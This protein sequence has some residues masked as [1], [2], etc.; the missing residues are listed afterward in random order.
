[1]RNWSLKARV[2]YFNDISSACDVK[3]SQTFCN[4]SSCPCFYRITFVTPWRGIPAE[5]ANCQ[6]RSSRYRP[7]YCCHYLI[8]PTH[9][10]SHSFSHVCGAVTNG[11]PLSTWAHRCRAHVPALKVTA[12]PSPGP[13]A[14][15][16][17]FASL[18]VCF[19]HTASIESCSDSHHL[20]QCVLVPIEPS[21]WQ[22]ILFESSTRLVKF[23]LRN[24]SA[25]VRSRRVGNVSRCSV[26]GCVNV[27]RSDTDGCARVSRRL[28]CP[29]ISR[30]IRLLFRWHTCLFVRQGDTRCGEVQRI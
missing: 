13:L 9:A 8:A 26:L 12:T 30:V 10:K 20:D 5:L 14:I 6:A 23:I 11:S 28:R 17:L 19:P 4:R 29:S 16:S 21:G 27:R 15:S 2:K 7:S 25:G 18:N 22:R 3:N 1:M 24:R